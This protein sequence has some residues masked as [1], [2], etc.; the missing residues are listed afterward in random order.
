ML[1]EV[2]TLLVKPVAVEK[3]VNYV[4]RIEE[5]GDAVVGVV[6]GIS[7]AIFVLRPIFEVKDHVR[8]TRWPVV[9]QPLIGAFPVLMSEDLGLT[10]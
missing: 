7:G 2:T 3:I 9:V 6:L 8:T 1:L 10:W 5:L 4:S